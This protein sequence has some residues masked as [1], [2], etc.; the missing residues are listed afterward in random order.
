ML[1]LKPVQS[2][3]NWWNQVS[4]YSSNSKSCFTLKCMT[5]RKLNGLHNAIHIFEML[6]IPAF[7]TEPLCVWEWVKLLPPCGWEENYRSSMVSHDC[8]SSTA[9]C[10]QRGSAWRMKSTCSFECP[11]LFCGIIC[12]NSY[13]LELHQRHCGSWFTLWIVLHIETV[14]LGLK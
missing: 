2:I 14:L 11:L 7:G 1:S 6:L 4:H 10:S 9:S 5:L 8:L 13:Q 12:I 3:A